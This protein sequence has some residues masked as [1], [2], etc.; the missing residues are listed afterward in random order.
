MRFVVLSL[1]ALL[2]SLA[3]LTPSSASSDDD[4]VY[5]ENM[6]D[7]CRFSI[8]GRDYNLWLLS[9]EY[10]VNGTNGFTYELDPCDPLLIDETPC[11]HKPSLH[12]CQFSLNTG[13]AFIIGVNPI[14]A[15]SN[16]GKVTVSYGGGDVCAATGRPRELYLTYRCGLELGMPFFVNEVHC[17]YYFDWETSLVC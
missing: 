3:L 15:G 14:A 5:A 1:A 13:H 17:N 7:G 8:A 10:Q 9:G 4:M 12:G 6:T 11:G 2:L 16:A